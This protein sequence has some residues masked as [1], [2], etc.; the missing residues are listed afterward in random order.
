M[1][2]MILVN[3]RLRGGASGNDL[4]VEDF[5]EQLESLLTSERISTRGALRAPRCGSAADDE[6]IPTG[7]RIGR[8]VD[9]IE[10]HLDGPLS[11]DR[12]AEEAELSRYYFSRVFLREVGQSPWSYVRDA[13][14]R[15]AKELLENGATPAEAALDAGFCDQAHLTNAM[16]RTEGT[17]PRKY[18]LEQ[19]EDRTDL[20]D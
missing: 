18:Q 15:R 17:T 11:V 12:L 20:Q 6:S 13:R 16:R 2:P 8:V 3:P 1:T 7:L 9:F 10:H 14:L 19:L 4:S 5:L